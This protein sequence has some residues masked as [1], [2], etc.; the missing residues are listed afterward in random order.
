[1]SNETV[2]T[3]EDINAW[4]GNLIENYLQINV[5]RLRKEGIRKEECII[6]QKAI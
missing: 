2:P 3:K 5:K 4:L 6:F 1:M